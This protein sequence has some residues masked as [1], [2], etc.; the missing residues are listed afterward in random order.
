MEKIKVFV[1]T[2]IMISGIYFNG[3]EALLLDNE[4]INIYISDTVEKELFD[5]TKYRYNKLRYLSKE[6]VENSLRV[7]LL[8]I[9]IIIKR[10]E[11]ESYI[12][13][14]SNLIQDQKDVN[15]L[16]AGLYLKPDFFITGDKHFHTPEITEVLNVVYTRTFLKFYNNMS[17]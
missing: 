12:Q 13:E 7:A 4:N 5:F 16:A 17:I 9:Y 6:E 11:Y 3:P 10:H 2:N 14:A 15:I 8:D 1:D